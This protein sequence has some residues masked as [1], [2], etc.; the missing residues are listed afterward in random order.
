[1]IAV[2]VDGAKGGWMAVALGDQGVVGARLV[3]ALTGV[4]AAWPDA[5]AYAIDMPIG[6]PDRGRRRADEA[7]RAFVGPRA[8]SVF[9]APPR[10][11]LLLPYAD[12]VRRCAELGAPGVSRQAYGLGAKILEVEPLAGREPRI[13]E[14][15][16]EC[17]FRELAGEAIE[18]P[19][20][21]WAGF[22]MRVRLLEAAGVVVPELPDLPIL[23]TVDAAA[24]A[25]SGLRVARG[26]A[27]TLPAE[28]VAGEPVIYA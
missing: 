2:G 12:A 19:K 8:A 11:A 10:A 5:D 27:H 20:T 24:A 28:P 6:L 22:R 1:V 17:S 23:D 18:H 25:W 16:P 15:H 7:A 14:V 3:T 9:F 21:T 26:A 13:V 4:L